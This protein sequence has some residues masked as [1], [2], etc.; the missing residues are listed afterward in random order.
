MRSPLLSLIFASCLAGPVVAREGPTGDT[1]YFEKKIRPLLEQ[2]CLKCH[3]EQ[4]RAAGK[5]RGGLLLDSAQGWKTGGDTGPA[6]LPG[7][8]AESVLIQSLS[9]AGDLKMPPSGRL[10]DSAITE[11]TE[12]VRRGAPDPRTGA[13]TPAKTTG[14]SL[15]QGKKFWSYQPVAKPAVPAVRDTAWP[16]GQIDRFILARLEAEGLRPTATADRLTLYRRL[17]FDLTG[18]PPD[19]AAAEAFARATDPMALERAVD[20]ML[21]SPAFGERWA[22]HWLDV[23]RF[24][25]S[26][27]LRGFIFPNAWR[28]R[29]F[30]IDAFNQ[31]MPYDRFLKLQIAGDLIP[32]DSQADKARNQIATTYLVL[33]NTNFEEQVKGQLDMDVVDDMLD[34]I[35][36]GILGQTL[37]CAR[38]H[39]HKFDPIPTRDYYALAGILAN[40]QAMDHANV[41]KWIDLP[42]PVDDQ[43]ETVLAAR[44][45]RIQELEKKIKAAQGKKGP[46]KGVL[47][48]G[49]APGIVVDDEQARKVGDWQQSTHSGTYL[50]KGYSHDKNAGKGTKTLTFQPQDLPAGKYSVWLAYSHGESRSEAVPVTVLCAEGEV[51]KKISLKPVPPLEGRYVSLGEFTFDKNV[52]YVIVSNEGT[53]GHVTADAVVFV[54]ASKKP[55]SSPAGDDPLAGLRRELN[56]LKA[57]GPERPR[58][59]G[60][61]ERKKISDA[62]VHIRG[63][64]STLGAVA[65]RGVLQ[66]VSVPAPEMPASQSGR[67]QLAEWITRPDHPLTARVM[68][69]RVWHWLFGAGLVRSVDNFGTTGDKPSHPELLDYLAGQLVTN[70]WSV[71]RLVREIVLSKTYGQASGGVTP[72]DPDNRLL[73]HANRRRLD[74][75][76]IRDAM[77]SAG[78]NLDAGGYGGPGFGKAESDYSFTTEAKVRS[79]YLPVLRNVADPC[80]EVFDRADPSR[81][82]GARDTSTVAPQALFLLNNPLVTAQARLAA[83]RV[84][85]DSALADDAARKERLW[86]II[87][88]R[89]PT[90]AEARQTR[91]RW[92]SGS[93]PETAWAALAHALFASPDFRTLD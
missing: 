64:V 8:P 16:A 78:S 47:A 71:K 40:V 82:V 76:C 41:S 54:P 1:A 46:A 80:L 44:E 86:R 10:P 66:V 55:S 72:N 45:S 28:Y 85:T 90:Q 22:R 19:P 27:T 37:G 39:D 4:A 69:N 75:E 53:A 29:D 65:P 52:G 6:I 81:V 50:G 5:L 23:A 77:L 70:G 38:C 62:R 18:L 49:D 34:T 84:L 3:S 26:V 20:S 58:S 33:G 57:K 12:W 14:L 51:E 61:R 59:M 9:H 74:A 68:A 93:D 43:T 21:A 42:L 63:Q 87:L 60:V 32:A 56:E 24:G 91:E 17:S 88:G 83:R 36:T 2:H 31:D 13:I 11:L 73:A 48:L 25:E 15:E 79:V 92:P 7:K 30:V 67:L 35:G 89:P